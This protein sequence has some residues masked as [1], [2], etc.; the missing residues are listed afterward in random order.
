[1]GRDVRDLQH[2][3]RVFLSRSFF[4]VCVCVIVCVF[5]SFT[6]IIRLRRC[7]MQPLWRGGLRVYGKERNLEKKI[8]I[9]HTHSD[10]EFWKPGECQCVTKRP[11]HKKNRTNSPAH[12]HTHTHTHTHRQTNSGDTL[13]LAGRQKAGRARGPFTRLTKRPASKCR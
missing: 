12:A 5:F 9:A 13:S 8:H 11:Y 2:E 6:V 4:C 1:M 10:H 7:I 3:T